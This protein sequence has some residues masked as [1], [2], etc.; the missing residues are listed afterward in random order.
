MNPQATSSDGAR[1]RIVVI[2]DLIEDTDE[3]CEVVKERDGYPCL[4][5]VDRET[6]PGGAGAVAEMVRSLGVPCILVAD[7]KRVSRKRRFIVDGK[8]QFRHDEDQ[9]GNAATT[10]PEAD[11]V[12]VA[13]YGKGV[14][15]PGAWTRI[16]GRYHGK[17]IIVDPRRPPAH[18]PGAT[19]F[20]SSHIVDVPVNLPWIKTRSI[21][22]LKL[23]LEGD[24]YEFPAMRS[25]IAVDPCGA[26]DMVLATLGV[27]RLR[28]KS[29]KEACEAAVINAAEV[30]KVWGARPPSNQPA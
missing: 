15:S 4:K 1:K 21:N 8:V 24:W 28:G 5:T 20:K 25:D 19:A 22:G 10:F 2:G 7:A 27:E 17:E 16:V 29:W 30:C 14:M 12:L 18:Y 9:Q 6:R 3:F 23:R 26:G 13:D 11:L